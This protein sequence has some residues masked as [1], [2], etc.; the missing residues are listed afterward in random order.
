MKK[1]NFILAFILSIFV[2]FSCEKKSTNEISD[3]EKLPK[4]FKVIGV[5]DYFFIDG[6][7]RLF[8]YCPDN[9]IHLEWW[10]EYKPFSEL[11]IWFDKTIINC[12]NN[13]Q[14]MAFLR[15]I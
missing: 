1:S 13:G 6:Y 3:L 15:K 11:T 10:G 8:H 5:N 12:L 4:E 7:E 9:T 2:I 14:E